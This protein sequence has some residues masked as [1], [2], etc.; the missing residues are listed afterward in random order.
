MFLI[1]WFSIASINLGS[2]CYESKL[3]YN[4]NIA[5]N[6]VLDWVEKKLINQN[7]QIILFSLIL[8]VISFCLI[9][10]RMSVFWFCWWFN[11][12]FAKVKKLLHTNINQTIKIIQL[13]SLLF[14]YFYFFGFN[15]HFLPLKTKNIRKMIK[16]SIKAKILTK[17]KNNQWH[18]N[19]VILSNIW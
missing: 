14:Y 8:L 5:K 11:H 15:Q 13:L 7:N 9:Y 6:K 10:L 4:F 16:K 19:D 18:Q 17:F 1:I 3:G 2:L 12:C